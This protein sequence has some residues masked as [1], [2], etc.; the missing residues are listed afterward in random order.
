MRRQII[1][2]TGMYHGKKC[3]NILGYI[4]DDKRLICKRHGREIEIASELGGSTVVIKCEICGTKVCIK[5]TPTWKN[6]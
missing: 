3:N 5:S 6:F 4:T 1:T 2:C